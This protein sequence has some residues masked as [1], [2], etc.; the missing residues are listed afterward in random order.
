MKN[1]KVFNF[2]INQNGI[3]SVIN[4]FDKKKAN[5]VHSHDIGT[6][7]VSGIA[8]GMLLGVQNN[9]MVGV[10]PGEYEGGGTPEFPVDPPVWGLRIDTTNSNPKTS[11]TLT[12]NSRFGYPLSFGEKPCLLK[13]G[14]V[15][16][17]LDPFDF[18]KKA[19]G[20]EADI[21]SG[22]DGDVMIEIPK[23]AY[24]ID[25]EGQDIVIKLTKH[26]DA[27]SID[28]RFKYLAHTRQTEG[29]REFL[30]YGAYQGSELGGKLRSL[31]KKWPLHSNTIGQFRSKA[32]LNGPGYGIVSFYPITLTQIMYLMKYRHLDSQSILG[33][34]VTNWTPAV[35]PFEGVG[36]GTCSTAAAT[37]AK[38]CTVDG[39]TKVAGN[40]AC[41]NFTIANTV[42]SPTLNI[43]GTGAHNI[44][45]NGV[46]AS[47][48]ITAGTHLF[49]FDGTNYILTPELMTGGT[50]TQ[51]MYSGSGD[52]ISH[53]KFAGIEDWYGNL[54]DRFDGVCT[55]A[56]WNL[57][58]AFDNFNDL[59]TGYEQRAKFTSANI[60]GMYLKRPFG[61]SE[62]GFLPYDNTGGS[63][64]TY[65]CDFIYFRNNTQGGFFGGSFGNSLGAG[66]FT[67]Y[68]SDPASD[69][70]SGNGSRLLKL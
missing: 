61:T 33:Q 19:N 34:G 57:Y 45:Y 20:D 39:F 2:M 44:L 8:D 48:N 28:P 16:Y 11:V 58:T 4:A 67:L 47:T 49:R 1:P 63:N 3:T 52:A 12:D 51:G 54:W 43:N 55:D 65:Y 6:M 5:V 25:Q 41:V 26:P 38:S 30:Y 37:A 14:E 64:S 35:P 24:F 59:G 60:E 50:E 23:M 15:N 13:E 21:T 70:N 9:H 29:D 7:T 62:V 56:G 53:V 22:E 40:F 36:L 69:S 68:L 42:A 10:S 46:G 27:K 18:T 31:S 17:Y 32:E 66:S